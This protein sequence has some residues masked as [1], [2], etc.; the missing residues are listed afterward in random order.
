[1][2]HSIE[3][4]T[5]MFIFAAMATGPVHAQEET[6]DD[7]AQAQAGQDDEVA[8]TPNNP[9][10][11]LA[12]GAQGVLYDFY[13]MGEEGTNADLRF[14]HF[15]AEVT[16]EHIV[17]IF[18]NGSEEEIAH[19]EDKYDLEGQFVRGTRTESGGGR[20]ST[21]I[22]EPIGEDEIEVTKM[23]SRNGG[24][25][26]IEQMTYAY[27]ADSAGLPLVSFPLAFAYHIRE[28]HDIFTADLG[29]TLLP[30]YNKTPIRFGNIGVEE[31]D[32][33][34][35]RADAHVLFI[36]QDE[37][38]FGPGT[39]LYC[40]DDGTIARLVAPNGDLPAITFEYA[41][42]EEIAEMFGEDALLE[43]VPGVED[44]DVAAEDEEE[45]DDAE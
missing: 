37:S 4:F 15:K 17:F 20:S 28:E 1:M 32:F 35:Q 25:A 7:A 22:A 13:L 43:D 10:E 14:L 27:D 19:D 16:D 18:R 34:G 39:M 44:E 2:R 36:E 42:P 8:T 3:A 23:T 40:L 31:I 26:E 45:P 6:A 41:T 9:A 33:Q 21:W 5:L 24:H 38:L 12:E 29:L 30:N 11:L